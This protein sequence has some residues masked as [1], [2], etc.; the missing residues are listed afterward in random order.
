MEIS[1]G[2]KLII[3]TFINGA[4][5]DYDFKYRH[6]EESPSSRI[7]GICFAYK[8]NFTIIHQPVMT[9]T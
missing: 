6:P 4:Q 1:C 8:N 3:V 7:Q 5:W 9:V 2:Q